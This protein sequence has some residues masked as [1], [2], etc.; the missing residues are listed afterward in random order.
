MPIIFSLGPDIANWQA[1]FVGAPMHCGLRDDVPDFRKCVRSITLDPLSEFIYWRMKLAPRA[2]HVR[3]GACYN[4]KKLH[5]AVEHD[6]PKVRSFFGAWREM[7]EIW[8]RQQ[9]EPGYQFDTPV[10]SEAGETSPAGEP[11]AASVGELAPKELR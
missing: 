2:P 11:E 3:R 6:M 8:N 4:L 7:R 9:R 10:P 1:Y 5:R